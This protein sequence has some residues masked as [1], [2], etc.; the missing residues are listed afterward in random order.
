MPVSWHRRQSSFVHAPAWE[1]EFGIIGGN[2]FVAKA[3]TS[4]DGKTSNIELRQTAA[5]R[6]E[7]DLPL[8]DYGSYGLKA[9]H[10]LEGDTVAVSLTAP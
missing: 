1:D 3:V 4:P 10:T 5:G 8:T 9:D 7:G 6:Y 2:A